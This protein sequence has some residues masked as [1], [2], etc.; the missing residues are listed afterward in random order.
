MSNVTYLTHYR[1]RTAGVVNKQSPTA[2]ERKNALAWANADFVAKWNS[3]AAKSKEDLDLTFDEAVLKINPHGRNN[4]ADHYVRAFKDGN[5]TGKGYVGFDITVETTFKIVEALVSTTGH[6][7]VSAATQLGKTGMMTTGV[8]LTKLAYQRRNRSAFVGVL[9]FQ[10]N[11][12]H[13]QVA[14]DMKATKAIYY[15]LEMSEDVTLHEVCEDN[16][17]DVIRRTTVRSAEEIYEACLTFEIP[18]DEIVLFVDEADYGT[19]ANGL[20]VKI[21]AELK[22]YLGSNI[23]VRFVLISATPYEFEGADHVHLIK[24]NV[25]KTCGYVG[26]WQGRQVPINSIAEIASHVGISGLSDAD[27]EDLSA[28]VPRVCD[29]VVELF[30]GVSAPKLGLNGLPANGGRAIVLRYSTRAKN[31]PPTEALQAELEKVGAIEGFKVL[32]FYEDRLTDD[33]G[34]SRFVQDLLDEHPD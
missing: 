21:T 29:L 7:A 13:E 20:F 10:R 19:A 4:D 5:H 3:Y 34:R 17:G 22:N 31:T 9:A 25:P 11:I 23:P 32:G 26:L 15:P 24:V 27:F 18:V 12:A 28:M 16:D 30:N 14:E 1:R 6:V 2:R 8:F 33:K